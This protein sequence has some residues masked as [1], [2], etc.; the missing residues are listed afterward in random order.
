MKYYLY[1]LGAI[2]CWASLP[3]ATGSGLKELSTE[4]LMF[5]SFSSAAIFLYVQDL[6][7]LRTARVFIPGIK[8]SLMGVWGIFLYHYLYYLALDNAPLAEGAILATTWSFWIVVFS[9]LLLFRKLK[10][11]I[12][13][14][15]LVGLFGAGLVIGAGKELSFE[16]SHM[17]GY[18]LALLCGLIWSSFS[19]GLSRVKVEKEPMTAFTLYAAILSAVLFAISMPHEMP[20]WQALGSAVYLGCVPLGLSFYLWN[21][22]MTGGNIVIIG[23]LS[24]LTPPLAVLLVAVIHHQ[25]VS[26]QVLLGM[27][28]ILFASLLGRTLVRYER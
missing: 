28:V 19:V 18:L 15:A 16:M 24:Y 1:A 25:E 4:E 6:L 2:L 3:A 23:F 27:A 5:Y 11:S 8:A 13:V 17:K 22:A 7:T 14:T 20:S 10:V 21:R 9:S 26:G 12:V